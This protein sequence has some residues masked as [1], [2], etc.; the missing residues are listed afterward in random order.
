[1]MVQGAVPSMHIKIY[2]SIG[3]M[4]MD[5]VNSIQIQAA[6]VVLEERFIVKET[7]MPNQ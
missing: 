3:M 2:I 4:L 5:H 1:M 6:K 7:S